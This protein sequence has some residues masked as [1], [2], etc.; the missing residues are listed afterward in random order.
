[1]TTALTIA[2]LSCLG[3]SLRVRWMTWSLRWELASTIAVALLGLSIVLTFCLGLLQVAGHICLIAGAGA[4][5]TTAVSRIEGDT[6]HIVRRWVANPMLAGVLAMVAALFLGGGF[7][8][9]LRGRQWSIPIYIEIYSVA[10]TAT[11]AY[12]LGFA[13]LA[14]VVLAGDVRQRRMAVLFLVPCTAGFIAQLGQMALLACMLT[15]VH[16]WAE[17][18]AYWAILMGTAVWLMGFA[19][20]AAYSWQQ[21]MKGFK[22][23]QRGLKNAA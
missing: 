18:R 4:I 8:A 22:K 11:T 16:L 9:E 12:L 3:W 23:L 13:I 7:T 1:M 5:A 21:K 20:A 17:E 2:A 10:M 6:W 15:D 19:I 14:L